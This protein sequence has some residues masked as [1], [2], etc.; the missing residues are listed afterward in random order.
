[1]TVTEERRL[2]AIAALAGVA[3]NAIAIPYVREHGTRSVA[4]FFVGKIWS[5]VPGKFAMVDLILVVVAFHAWA[6]PES[7]RLGIRRWWWATLTMTFTVG[8]GTAIPFFLAARARALRL[9]P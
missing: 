6:L 5:T 1:M 7:G 8:I 9:A 3:Q 2:I 4:D